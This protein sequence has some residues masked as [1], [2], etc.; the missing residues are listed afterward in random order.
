MSAAAESRV[1]DETRKKD[2]TDY[3]RHEYERSKDKNG[4][5]KTPPANFLEKIWEKQRKKKNEKQRDREI[6]RGVIKERKRRGEEEEEE[7]WR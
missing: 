4:S 6:E 3:R 2:L 7:E 1:D 5:I